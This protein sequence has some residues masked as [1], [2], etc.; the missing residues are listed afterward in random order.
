MHLFFLTI[1]KP[2]KQHP[3]LKEKIT[4]SALFKDFEEKLPEHSN[5]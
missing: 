4:H 5:N 3:V 1:P 2:L